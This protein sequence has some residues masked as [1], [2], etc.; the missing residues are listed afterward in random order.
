MVSTT[1]RQKFPH[2][3]FMGEETYKPG[4][5]LTDEPTFIVDPID[6]T[7]NFIHTFPNVCISLGFAV[8]RTPTVGVVYNPFTKT[9]YSAIRGQ[10]AFMNETIPLP[11]RQPAE[12]LIDLSN[13]LVAVEWGSD[14]SG[15]DYVVKTATF[16]KLCA[17]K[18]EGG[19]MV[20][21]LR[22]LGSA[23]LNLC[24]VA[25]GSLDVY[26]EAGCWAW[27]VCA[28][29]AILKE[30]GGIIVDANPGNWEPK[31]DGRRYL[32]VRGAIDQRKIVEEFWGVVQGRFEMGR[33]ISGP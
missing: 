21:S 8:K 25:A 11:L 2:Y 14:R 18:S 4:D 27:D 20:H 26:W 12:S 1:L 22:S 33:E 16:S 29:W 6:G 10:G 17:A 9:L 32:A 23:A 30:A 19:A 5:V 24:Q 7:T 13:C 28:G 15:P 3:A 31:V